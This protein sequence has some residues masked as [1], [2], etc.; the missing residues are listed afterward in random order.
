MKQNTHQAGLEPAATIEEIEGALAMR[1]KD[2]VLPPSVAPLYAAYLKRNR[3]K[4]A[5]A[6]LLATVII[7]N[8][9]LI[10]DYL[11]MPQS[12]WIAVALHM[13]ITPAILISPFAIARCTTSALRDLVAAIVPI[14]MV[15]QIM[16]IYVLSDTPAADHYQYLT[17]M[18]FIFMTVICRLEYRH[19]LVASAVIGAIYLGV[20]AARHDDVDALIIGATVFTA[21]AFLTLKAH[22][23]MERDHRRVFLARQKDDMRRREAENEAQRDPLTGLF[24]RRGLSTHCES[25]WSRGDPA[26][27]PLAVILLDIDHFK[28]FNDRYG[29]LGGDMCLQRISEVIRDISG[30]CEGLPTRFGGEEFVWVLSRISI[31]DAIGRAEALRRR[32]EA[33]AIPHD[34][35]QAGPIV[36][37]SIGVACGPVS[38]YGLD[39][40]IRAA[41]NA[42]YAA[43]KAGRNQVWPPL[44]QAAL[45]RH[46]VEFEPVLRKQA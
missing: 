37:V 17:I 40:L 27:S 25:L 6:T 30:D 36:T 11:L 19:T 29:H 21:A 7:Y 34:G 38:A 24:N 15:A 45:D 41:D 43:K 3:I 35:P 12:F 26:A 16:T 4:R 28:S 14:A 23:Q 2:V 22:R 18:T 9:F 44:P 32:I 1:T 33:L 8:A 20:L 39:D 31:Y 5:W 42:L 13:F 10:V 46:A